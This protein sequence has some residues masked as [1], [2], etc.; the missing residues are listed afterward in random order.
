M[1]RHA[2]AAAMLLAA[3][4]A[5]ANDSTAELRAG[6]IVFLRS[7]EI[8]MVKEDLFISQEKV[9]V[10][11]VFRNESDKDVE[12]YVAF[13]MP[14]ITASPGGIIALE[15]F[16]EDNFLH[17]TVTQ[18]G[19]PIKAN[20]QQ[21]IDVG[22]VDMTEEVAARGIPFL[23]LSQQTLDA[24]A[25]LPADVLEDWRTRGLIYDDVFDAGKGW[26]NN[27]TPKWTLRS[28]YWWK[29]TFPA[30]KDARVHHEYKPGVGGTAGLTFISD[31]KPS[32]YGYE[33]YVRRYCIDDAFMKTAA[34]LEKATQEGK[35][36]Y[37]MESRIAYVLTTG[38]NW[39]GPIADFRLVVDKGSEKNVISFCGEG[40]KKIGPTT[41]EMRAKDFYPEKD[42]EFLI[43]V[44]SQQ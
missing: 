8:A 2:I 12:T 33:D 24:V 37:Y 28:V 35:G 41:F 32:D 5:L 1:I 25:K 20:L 22:G 23:P 43:L 15:N 10:D 26:E 21:R 44:P 11:Y 30:G 13:P 7:D 29:T 6:G 19:R 14:E 27:P 34:K 9:T 3:G 36:P 42:L 17:F 40:V 18:D 16:D 4:N 39:A 38:A 31:G